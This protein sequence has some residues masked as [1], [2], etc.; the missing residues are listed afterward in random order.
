MAYTHLPPPAV[1]VIPNAVAVQ[2]GSPVVDGL[3]IPLA[4][5]RHYLKSH[6][7]SS[8]GE[9]DVFLSDQLFERFPESLQEWVQSPVPTLTRSLGLYELEPKQALK[10]VQQLRQTPTPLTPAEASAR[11]CLQ[12]QHLQGLM[13]MHA[14]LGAF[15]LAPP[16]SVGDKPKPADDTPLNDT[17]KEM[18]ELCVGRDFGSDT[19]GEPSA[20]FAPL[21]PEPRGSS[22]EPMLVADD[23]TDDFSDTSSL[24]SIESSPEEF[25]EMAMI[26]DYDSPF[27]APPLSESA[28]ISAKCTSTLNKEPPMT[29]GDASATPA[30]AAPSKRR[31][32]RPAA[33]LRRSKRVADLSTTQPLPPT[34]RSPSTSTSTRRRR[35]GSRNSALS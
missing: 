6:A 34:P 20:T 17:E 12:V 3:W 15:V 5:A 7:A 8:S 10:A 23:G 27:A 22:V 32:K 19:D 35:R 26:N 1:D 14:P 24:S 31:A 16:L 33:P 28:D 29:V 25:S 13:P 9:L 11:Q 21:D 18:F 2:K 30:V 4:H